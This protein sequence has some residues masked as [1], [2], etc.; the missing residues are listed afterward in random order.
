MAGLI[1]LAPSQPASGP[2]PPPAAPTPQQPAA[3]T[4]AGD[5][6]AR[7]RV[8]SSGRSSRDRRPHVP[9]VTTGPIR[10]TGAYDDRIINPPDR[11]ATRESVRGKR[12]TVP[13]WD[14]I[15]FGPRRQPDP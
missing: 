5:S 15:L 6:E 12:T 8:T 7:H 13:S 2:Y 10:R 4:A 14:E 9:A 11:P 1:P 3:R